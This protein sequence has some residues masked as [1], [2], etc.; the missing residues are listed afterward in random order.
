MKQ[1]FMVERFEPIQFRG[2]ESF[3]RCEPLFPNVWQDE[4]GWLGT[5]VRAVPCGTAKDASRGGI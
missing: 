1:W 2:I 5:L 3:M 4:D